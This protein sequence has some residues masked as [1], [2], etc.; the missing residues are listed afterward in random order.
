MTNEH[1]GRRFLRLY[2]SV[3]VE[4][5]DEMAEKAGINSFGLVDEHDMRA[6]TV[7]AIITRLHSSLNEAL[8]ATEGIKTISQEIHV[9]RIENGEWH[10]PLSM[11][12]P[13]RDN[14]GEI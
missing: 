3:E 8:R 1:D 11:G 7:D 6:S 5:A 13:V 10:Y 9:G 12:Y 2:A 14:H 4:V